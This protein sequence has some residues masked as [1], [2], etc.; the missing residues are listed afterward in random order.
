MLVFG[1]LPAAIFLWLRRRTPDFGAFHERVAKLFFRLEL[2]CLIGI[3]PWVFGFSL[4]GVRLDNGSPAFAARVAAY[5]S[6]VPLPGR[7]SGPFGTL[8]FSGESQLDAVSASALSA[9]AAEPPRTAEVGQPPPVP[10]DPDAEAATGRHLQWLTAAIG[11]YRARR[12]V[13]PA[14]LDDLDRPFPAD[15]PRVSPFDPGRGRRGYAYVP[16][17]LGA[18]ADGGAVVVYDAAELDRTGSAHAACGAGMAVRTLTRDQ[19]A[20]T[21]DLPHR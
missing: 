12:G 3:V 17:N 21:V 19:L 15:D 7:R 18:D 4:R 1:F 13:V 9:R 2:I 5:Q 20:E 14:S 8:R 10:V 6:G 11:R 16:G